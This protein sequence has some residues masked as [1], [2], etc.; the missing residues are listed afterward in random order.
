MFIILNL[1]IKFYKFK[2]LAEVFYF[3]IVIQ[4]Y[5]NLVLIYL[6]QT[7]YVHLSWVI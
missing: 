3:I 5:K 2:D 4:V 7:F 1:I 6:F